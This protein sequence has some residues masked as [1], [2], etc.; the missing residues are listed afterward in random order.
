[1]IVKNFFIF[2]LSVFSILFSDINYKKNKLLLALDPFDLSNFILNKYYPNQNLDLN[3]YSIMLD[4]STNFSL[5]QS[6]PYDHSFNRDVE[7]TISELRYKER[8]ADKYFRAN[9]NCNTM[10]GVRIEFDDGWGLVRASNTQP[11]IVC[12][13]EAKSLAR[14]QEIQNEILDKLYDFGEI[15]LGN[16]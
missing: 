4:G 1:M 14:M 7:G 10:D 6:I 5:Y 11:V 13:F 12:R 15:T 16:C 9:Y 3:Y 2:S 8:K